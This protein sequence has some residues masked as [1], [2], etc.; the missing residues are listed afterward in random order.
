MSIKNQWGCIQEPPLRLKTYPFFKEVILEINWALKVQLSLID[1]KYGLNRDGQIRGDGDELGWIMLADNIVAADMVCC[2]LMR[3]DPLTV[4][5]LAFCH[6]NI[7][8]P[9]FDTFQF[10]RDNRAFI[11]PQVYLRREFWDYPGYFAFRSPL[12]AYLACH[13]PAAGL[14][15]K[16][17]YLF[18]SKFY[19][20]K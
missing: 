12:L 8:V 4:D 3:I 10:N 20:H 6:Q 2:R 9:S 15:H 16:V 5:H 13:S 18:R 1:G 11:G 19:D 14:L 7:A 17:L